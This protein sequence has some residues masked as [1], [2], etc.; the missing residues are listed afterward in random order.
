MG[1]QPFRGIDM[2]EYETLKSF[3]SATEKHE[4]GAICLVCDQT[5]PPGVP[6][7]HAEWCEHKGLFLGDYDVARDAVWYD[8]RWIPW[9]EA[10]DMVFLIE[11]TP[12]PDGI[13][14]PKG[15]NHDR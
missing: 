7:H 4:G 13:G 9:S 2:G 10:K 6:I 15:P 5:S 8:D 14:Q 3:G 11:C 12:A 1:V